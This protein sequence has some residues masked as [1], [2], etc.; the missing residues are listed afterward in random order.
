VG[1][2]GGG[3]V[4][5]PGDVSRAHHG[6]LFLDELP[7]CRRRVLEVLR[8]PLEDGITR[9]RLPARH[10]CQ[11]P[12]GVSRA[13]DSRQRLGSRTITAYCHRSDRYAR[14]IAASPLHFRVSNTRLLFAVL[15]HLKPDIGNNQNRTDARVHL[16]TGEIPPRRWEEPIATA[17]GRLVDRVT[18]Q[19]RH[20]KNKREGRTVLL[21]PE[22]KTA[23]A[24]WLLPLRQ[25]PSCTAQTFIFQ[26]RKGQNRPIR[27]VQAWRILHE[28]VT[29]NELINKLC[30]HAVRKTFANR[31]YHQLNHDL[32]K[33]QR[34]MGRK[35]INST[36]AYLSF[37]VDEID[38]AILAS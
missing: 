10:G 28:A 33:T 8:Q 6:V 7:A 35:N 20:M 38:Q 21:H 37:V 19:R 24:T 18:V 14:G 3:Q 1:L 17:Q 29:T 27:D 5:L 25:M 36:V 11:H 12:C 15:E 23:L 30:T 31:V 9:I 22:A 16:E 13:S 32:G 2:V 26:S 34:A 4:P